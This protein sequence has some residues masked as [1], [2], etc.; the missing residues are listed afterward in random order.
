MILLEVTRL[1]HSYLGYLGWSPC[2]LG[3]II[4]VKT[5]RKKHN[6]TLDQCYL[7][8]DRIKNITLKELKTGFICTHKIEQKQEVRQL[9]LMVPVEV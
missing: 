3:S 8:F 4:Y 9:E 2:D 6:T 5:E 7:G 1:E